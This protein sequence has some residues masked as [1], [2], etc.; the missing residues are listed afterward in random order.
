MDDPNEGER[1]LPIPGWEDSYEISDHGRVRSISRVVIRR[2]GNPQTFRGRILTPQVDINGYFVIN[3]MRCGKPTRLRIPRL[4][5][6]VFV[7]Q[8]PDG[9]EC[10]HFDGTT[11]NNHLT[12]LKWGTRSE[13]NLDRQ[14]HGTD[15]QRNKTHCPYRHRLELPN[16]TKS[17]FRRGIRECL[18]CNWTYAKQWY[19]RRRGETVD[20]QAVSDRYYASI[21]DSSNADEWA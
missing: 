8:C 1:W 20:F 15:F 6:T 18:A 2:N 13:N 9:M 14:R 7:G 16:L 5:L 10:L 4:V 11:T 3:L 12:N 19:A 21:M 17:K